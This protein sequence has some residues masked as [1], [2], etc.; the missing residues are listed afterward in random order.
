MF[1]KLFPVFL[2]WGGVMFALWLF[3]AIAGSFV[4]IGPIEWF[5]F[6]PI[7]AYLIHAVAVM[8]QAK[9]ERDRRRAELTAASSA[10]RTETAE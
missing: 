10:P 9:L 7:I 2:L 6:V 5:M 8:K 3:F 4:D 1:S